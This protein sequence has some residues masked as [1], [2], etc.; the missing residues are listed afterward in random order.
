ARW[1][2]P[3]GRRCAARP[4][5]P[6]ALPRGR[7]WR[8][9][10]GRRTTRRALPAPRHRR[11]SWW[12]CPVPWVRSLLDVRLTLVAVPRDEHPRALFWGPSRGAPDWAERADDA[13]PAGAV[14][15]APHDG[16]PV[17][18]TLRPSPSSGGRSG[19][20][21]GSGDV[22]YRRPRGRTSPTTGTGWAPGWPSWPWRPLPGLG[23]AL[24]TSPC[25]THP[26]ALF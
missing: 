26:R 7:A 13:G 6:I 11:G 8:G 20:L 23:R 15:R 10:G 2:R 3:C 22:G 17:S 4:R 18:S 24:V 19:R 21:R 5:A 9:R 16:A 1:R 25:M 14:Q 12:R